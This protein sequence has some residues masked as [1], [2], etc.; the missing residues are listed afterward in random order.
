MMTLKILKHEFTVCKPSDLTKIRFYDRF[1]FIG[2]T[3]DEL[4]L[5]CYT[6]SVPDNVTVREDGWRGFYIE[7]IIDFALTGVLSSILTPLAEAGIG[8]FAVSTYNT[9]YIFVKEKV[10]ETALGL[11]Q[12]RGYNLDRCDTV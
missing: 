9:D 1:C 6:S 4:S 12:E 5:V 8:I 11:L 2:K 7:G 10:F 3:A